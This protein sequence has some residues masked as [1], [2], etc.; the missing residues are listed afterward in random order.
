M[1]KR[2]RALITS[3]LALARAIEL[4]RAIFYLRA[5]LSSAPSRE[6]S[7]VN[8]LSRGAPLTQGAHALFL[9]MA[10]DCQWPLYPK[11]KDTGRS[12]NPLTRRAALTGRAATLTE[13]P[14]P[15]IR[16][17][18]GA[19]LSIHFRIKSYALNSTSFD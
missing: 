16:S 1:C 13:K 7:N 11:P 17:A 2:M 6:R 9:A 3:A 5:P 18:A 4:A 12:F 19:P 8:V 14:Q 15:Y 10:T